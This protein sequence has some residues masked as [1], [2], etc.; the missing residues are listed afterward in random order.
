MDLREQLYSV[1][2]VSD[3]DK[4]NR[5]L[6]HA[7]PENR[8]SPVKTVS[9]VG[10]AKRELLE[11]GY[12]IVIINT[13]LP[14]DYGTRLA[15]DLSADVGL[16]VLLFVKSDNFGDVCDQV[17][18]CGVLTV[19]KPANG[20]L[21]LQSLILLCATRDRLRRMEQKTASIEEKMEEIRLINRAKW[22]LIDS[23]GMTEA[24]A[25]RY[26]ERQAMNKCIS[27]K[28]IAEQIISHYK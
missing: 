18:G 8:Y 5:A 23:L 20:Q 19:S 16:G 26:I 14:D 9:G 24:E 27:K 13:P 1:L 12:D 28:S 7:L 2:V 4:F 25:H 11:R 15:I 22:K 21:V 17:A 3:S 6:M 10:A